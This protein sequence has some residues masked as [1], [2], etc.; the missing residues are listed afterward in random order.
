MAWVILGEAPFRAMLAYNLPRLA[1]GAAIEK[2]FAY[3][4]GIAASHAI[5]GLVQKLELLGASGATRQVAVLASWVYT[6]VLVL[7]VAISAQT[8]LTMP[9][10]RALAWLALL[11]LSSLRS[12]F[13]PDTYALFPILWI[14]T[15][16]LAQAEWPSRRV[17]GLAALIAAANYLVP[18]VPIMP[19]P[20]L[21]TL[22]LVL[23]VVFIGLCVSVLVRVRGTPGQTPAVTPA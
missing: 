17:A 12:P 13:T 15:L 7:V 23:Q 21:L 2:A 3:P 5:F 4:D 22:G 9:L 6:G 19:V 18:T 1:S 8:P 16:L 14:L 10:S 11:Q 20:A